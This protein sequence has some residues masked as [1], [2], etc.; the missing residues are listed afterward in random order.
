MKQSLQ[1]VT[2]KSAA[3]YLQR[4]QEL[5]D[6]GQFRQR[7][8]S[9]S[10]VDCLAREITSGHW[11]ETHQGIAIAT[12][13]AV[14]DGR[15][16]L[17]AIIKAGV[18]V[19]TWVATDVPLVA[20]QNGV[21]INTIDAVD[22][23]RPRPTGT[24]LGISHGYTNGN[25]WAALAKNIVVFITGNTQ[26][27]LSLTTTLEV[28][29]IWKNEAQLLLDLK[30]HIRSNTRLWA[31]MSLYAYVDSTKAQVMTDKFFTKVGLKADEPVLKLEQFV[32]RTNIQSYGPIEYMSYCS[33]SMK[34][35]YEGRTLSKLYS[36]DEAR[37]WLLNEQGKRTAQLR[38]IVFAK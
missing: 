2:P 15:H 16:R 7:S 6:A 24:M 1:T 35:D 13:G 31:V 11:V 4:T 21:T 14:L 26:A 3:A 12:N 17:T 33:A 37:A 19:K 38:S 34:A 27:K 18:P 5:I 20:L 23:N 8:I 36:S 10:T 32:S 28:I 30:H 29:K 22:R 25:S 9:E